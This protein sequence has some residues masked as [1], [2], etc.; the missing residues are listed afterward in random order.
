LVKLEG[1]EVIE[2]NT[3]R[4]PAK[5]YIGEYMSFAANI[6]EAEEKRI[7]YLGVPCLR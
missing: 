6:P 4:E 7:Q 3:P 2:M 1:I 5:W